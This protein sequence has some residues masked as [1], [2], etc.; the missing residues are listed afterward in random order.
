QGLG[1]KA[2]H[3]ALWHEEASADVFSPSSVLEEQTASLPQKAVMEEV[4]LW[5]QRTMLG[6]ADEEEDNFVQ[7]G[8]KLLTVHKY[9]VVNATTEAELSRAFWQEAT[10][11]AKHGKTATEELEKKQKEAAEKTAAKK[12]AAEK[13]AAERAEKVEDSGAEGEEMGKVEVTAKTA[14][15]KAREEV[16]EMLEESGL[17]G[18]DNPKEDSVLLALPGFRFKDRAVFEIFVEDKLA[19]PLKALS[20]L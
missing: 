17:G 15:E 19:A 3:L 1:G 11:L 6:M 5:L 13:E 8:R 4:F 12:K 16:R 7:L 20:P 18:R 10:A 9:L 2:P 14:K